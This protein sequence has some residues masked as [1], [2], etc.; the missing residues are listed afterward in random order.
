LPYFQK[1]SGTFLELNKNA[2]VVRHFKKGDIVCREG[3][4]GS[5]A[6]YILDGNA[7][8]YLRIPMAHVKTEGGATGFFSKL[9]SRLMARQQH[10]REEEGDGLTTPLHAPVHLPYHNPVA[11]LGPGDLFGEMTC[12]SLYPRSATVCAATDC[13]MLEMLRNVLDIIQRNK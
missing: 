5:T 13:V 3:E 10:G 8:V 11:T 1:V 4:Y 2:V 7:D 9:T 6:F 12:M